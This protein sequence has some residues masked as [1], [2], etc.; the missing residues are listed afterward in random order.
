MKQLFIIEQLHKGA[1]ADSS[2]DSWAMTSEVSK[3]NEISWKF[4]AISYGKA[5]CIIRM[6]VALL[7]KKVFERRIR[8]YLKQKYATFS[9]SDNAVLA[10]KMYPPIPSRKP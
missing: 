2:V 8:N 9:Y 6:I 1:E 4:S 5:A 7:G 10:K 3:P